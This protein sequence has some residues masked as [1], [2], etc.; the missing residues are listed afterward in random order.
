MAKK[1]QAKKTSKKSSKKS[2]PSRKLTKPA[3]TPS[4]PKAR[5]AGATKPAAAK[6]LKRPAVLKG[7]RDNYLL[8]LTDAPDRVDG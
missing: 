7:D 5:A 6:R 8:V 4:K 1:E 2:T 3:A